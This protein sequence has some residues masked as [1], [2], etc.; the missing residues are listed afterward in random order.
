MSGDIAP[1]ELGAT[2]VHEHVLTNLDGVFT[3]PS[4]AYAHMADRPV[5]MEDLGWIRLNYASNRANIGLDDEELAA[6]EL[7]RYREAGGD[8]IVELSGQ[9]VGRDPEALLR[10]A[11]RT[12][13]RLVMGTGFYVEPFH[14]E[15]LAAQGEDEIAAIFVNDLLRGVEPHGI[16]SGIIGEIGC[17]W[18]LRDSEAKVLRAAG[19]AQAATGAAIT[20]HP[21]RDPSAPAEILSIVAGAG[22]DVTRTVIDHVDRTMFTADDLLALADTGCYVEYDMFGNESAH[23]PFAPI[24]LPNDAGRI[25][26]IQLL[27]EHGH[28]D[29]VLISHDVG[30][31][32]FLSAFGGY[33]YTHILQTVVP[34]MLSKGLSQDQIDT[35]LIANPRALLAF[36]PEGAGS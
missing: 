13:V 15:S 31:K 9:D 11:E 27:I 24:D 29:Q 17:S 1:E 2:L 10:L 7:L 34:K 28:I 8:T 33:G 12:G 21:G 30:F 4:P 20:I 26:W 36:D 23:Y 18:P 32:C 19:I 16:R 14:P 3:E 6:S 5:A 22:G 35:I 25:E